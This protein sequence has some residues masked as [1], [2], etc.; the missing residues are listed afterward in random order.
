MAVAAANNAKKP[1]VVTTKPSRD[2]NPNLKSMLQTFLEYFESNKFTDVQL[3]GSD[4]IVVEAHAVV[5]AAASKMLEAAFLSVPAGIDDMLVLT[6][7]SLSGRMLRTCIHGMYKVLAMVR[8]EFLYT[9]TLSNP[10]TQILKKY[11]VLK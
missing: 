6:M 4:G 1:G 5:L 11:A 3:V 7:S 10:T 9:F 8:K 2:A